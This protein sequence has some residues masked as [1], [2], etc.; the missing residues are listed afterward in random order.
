[1]LSGINAKQIANC[2]KIMVNQQKDWTFPEGYDHKNV[3]DKVLKI[4]LGGHE[5]D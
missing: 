3:S 2:V 4:I 5:I 1:M